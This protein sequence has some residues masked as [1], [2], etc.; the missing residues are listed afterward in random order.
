MSFWSFITGTTPQEEQQ[1]N[2]D[3]QKA[4]YEAALQRRIDAGTLSDKQLSADRSYVNGITLEDTGFLHS[5]ATRNE[6]TEASPDLADLLKDILVLA[7][8]AGAV[9]LFW[10]FGGV[11]WV[12]IA[13]KRKNILG[14]AWAAA[15]LAVSIWLLQKYAR[16]AVSD[17]KSIASEGFSFFK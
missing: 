2:L 8:V 3:K 15:G 13:I 17:A 16:A 11:L 12:R 1:A 7:A 14:I 4:A 5:F 10:S 6:N 9:W